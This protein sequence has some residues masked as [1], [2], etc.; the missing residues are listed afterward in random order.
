MPHQITTKMR[1]ERKKHTNWTLEF[2]EKT[3]AVSRAFHFGQN[4]YW[5]NAISGRYLTNEYKYYARKILE[6]AKWTSYDYWLLRNSPQYNRMCTMYV[7]C[8]NKIKKRGKNGKKRIEKHSEPFRMKWVAFAGFKRKIPTKWNPTS[9]WF[10]L[11]WFRFSFCF[12][13]FCCKAY[14]CGLAYIEQ[15]AH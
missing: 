1:R 4:Q 6:C 8:Q 11:V 3:E 15:R 10:D 12:V 13:L 7:I 14:L 5:K 9:V 2:T